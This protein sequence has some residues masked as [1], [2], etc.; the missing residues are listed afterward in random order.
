MHFKSLIISVIVVLI[1]SSCQKSATSPEEKKEIT[2]PRPSVDVYV[3]GTLNS[4]ATYWKNNEAHQI[5]NSIEG[6]SVANAIAVQGTDVYFA[7]HNLNTSGEKFVTFWKNGIPTY[8]KNLGITTADAATGIAVYNNDVY[9]TG[10]TERYNGPVQGYSAT[11]WKNGVATYFENAFDSDANAISITSSGDIYVAGKNN[12]RACYWKNGSIVYVGE[13]DRSSETFA[14][15]ISGT[16]VYLA[17]YSVDDVVNGLSR[18]A[19]VYWKNGMKTKLPIN[20]TAG[21]LKASSIAV[22][23]ADVYAV[24]SGLFDGSPS[25]FIK[26]IYWK[27]G[28]FN[29]ISATNDAK[30]SYIANAIAVTGND[31]YTA[32]SMNGKGYLLKNG[33]QITLDVN[34]ATSFDYKAITIVPR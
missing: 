12:G 1:F 21:A 5:S 34:G 9:V 2:P 23:G 24:G 8:L 30:F 4:K 3:S 22:S 14:I 6:T 7:G 20:G 10:Q 16:D 18:Q 33:L 15:Y 31:V 19:P 29:D 17:G 26:A 27:T 32:V 13:S 28:V 25:A 11:V